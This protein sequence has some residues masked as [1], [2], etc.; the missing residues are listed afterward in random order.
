MLRAMSTAASGMKA[1]QLNIDTISNNLANVNTTGVKKGRANFEDL[2]YRHSVLPGA[3]VNGGGMSATGTSTGAG[4]DD[5]FFPISLPF[6][7]DF[8]GTPITEIAVEAMTSA[9]LRSTIDGSRAGA[10]PSS[11]PCSRRTISRNSVVRCGLPDR[12]RT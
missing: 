8:Y 3:D 5:Y 10:L 12:S 2:F 6:S 9:A 4:D 7:F 1:Q 11:S